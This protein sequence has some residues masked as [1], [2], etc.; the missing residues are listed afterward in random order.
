MR[1]PR[2]RSAAPT[3]FS[4]DS[5]INQKKKKNNLV[6]KGLNPS[7]FSQSPNSQDVFYPKLA[8]SRGRPGRAPLPHAQAAT[9]SAEP[10]PPPTAGARRPRV[11]PLRAAARRSGAAPPSPSVP[12]SL[13]RAAQAP[14]AL[15]EPR[16]D[17]PAAARRP[18]QA[19]GPHGSSGL[20]GLP[21]APQG[22]EWR[23]RPPGRTFPRA[24]P[25]CASAITVPRSALAA[26]SGPR[27]I[28]GRSPAVPSRPPDGTCGPVPRSRGPCT[29]RLRSAPPVPLP[30]PHAVCTRPDGSPRPTAVR[31]AHRTPPR[32]MGAEQRGGPANGSGG[33]GHPTAAAGEGAGRAS[34]AL[35]GGGRGG[36]GGAGFAL[37]P[38]DSPLVAARA[39]HSAARAHRSPGSGGAGFRTHP[40]GWWACRS[41]CPPHPLPV[42]AWPGLAK[43][44]PLRA[45]PPCFT[46]EPRLAP[47]LC[48]AQTPAEPGNP[49]SA[50]ETPQRPS[51]TC[52]GLAAGPCPA[53]LRPTP[54]APLPGHRQAPV[55]RSA[56]PA[57]GV[58]A[59]AATGVG[60][61]PRGAGR[62][63]VPPSAGPQAPP[64][65]W[66]GAGAAAA[67]E[68]EDAGP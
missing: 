29:T 12:A 37:F 65:S 60:I 27:R 24:R 3:E 38:R 10:A 44:T 25:E 68:M 53:S 16:P 54:R 41:P 62:G 66:Q 8:G 63:R 42:A 59:G 64:P 55:P 26:T 33:R 57:V 7:A 17:S 1:G 47:L 67:Q 34:R 32:P 14:W 35:A 19:C 5:R 36:H 28:P 20:L 31:T 6:N 11:R 45:L 21:G 22:R 15:P 13:P 9:C 43:S 61:A 48:P 46:K 2:P 56:Q 18:L 4:G 40:S 58:G 52:P 50:G 49:T 39:A 23:P 30:A 51:E